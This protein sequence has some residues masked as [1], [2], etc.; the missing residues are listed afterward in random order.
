MAKPWIEGI[1]AAIG[2]RG[3]AVRVAIVRADGSTPREC[4]AAMLVGAGYIEETIGGGALELEA[5]AHARGLLARHGAA[6]PPWHREV[7][8]FALGPSLGQCCGGHA[9]VLFEVFTGRELPALADL[10]AATGADC[11]LILRPLEGGAPLQMVGDRRATGDWPLAVARAVRDMLSG[12]RAREPLLA[13]GAKGAGAW[14]IEPYVRHALP[15]YLYGAGHVGRALV[16]VLRDLPFALTWVD[17]S[18]ARF[19]EAPPPQAL[20]RIAA[21][22]ARFAGSAPAGGVHIVMT[23]SHALDLAICHALLRRADFRHLGLIGS[24]TKRA[25]FIKRLAEA[26]VADAQLSR[27]TCP[28]GI[29]GLVGKEPAVIAVSVAAALVQIASATSTR[30]SSAQ[31]AAEDASS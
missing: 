20:V 14:F 6:G 4:G 2:E 29:P 30:L 23:Y 1:A 8:D 17:T 25:R 13:G 24:E 5:I 22:P 16:H 9:R 26:G 10:P 28:I 18:P 31:S 15:L 3:P 19:P 7:R 21:D 27:L 11:A 12:A